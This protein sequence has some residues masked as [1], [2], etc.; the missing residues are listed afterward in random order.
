MSIKVRLIKEFKTIDGLDLF[1]PNSVAVF[2]DNIIV[3]D[4]GNNRVC[5]INPQGEY[6][7]GNV[8]GLG[9][10]KF[11]EPVYSTLYKKDIFICDWHNHRI[12][13][14]KN[15]KFINQIGI[16][17]NKKDSKFKNLLK[18]IFT[19]KSN[20]SFIIS[21]F[22]EGQIERKKGS[23]VQL[24]KNIFKGVFYYTFNFHLFIINFNNKN[25]INKPNGCIIIDNKLIFTQK[26][27]KCISIYDLNNKIIIQE[28]NNDLE[29]IGFGRLGQISYFEK[30]IYVCDETYNLLWIFTEKLKLLNKI[31]ITKYNIFSITLNKN[32]IV[33]CGESGY[34]IFNHNYEKIYEKIGG[35]EYHGVSLDNNSFYVCNRLNHKIEKYEIIEG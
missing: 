33:T 25:Y 4:G 22:S 31:S 23:K 28:I 35:G 12:M 5:V 18:L 14:Y 27:N 11:K 6:S 21:H 26:N 10:Y 9:K 16:F 2:E 19:L 13:Q 8:F 17:G 30:K 24:I 20:G 15:K 7:I 32:Y 1:L 34:S 29:E 3:T